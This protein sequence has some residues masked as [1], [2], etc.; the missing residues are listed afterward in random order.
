ME[1]SITQDTCLA[2]LAVLPTGIDS[3]AIGLMG[4]TDPSISKP[5]KLILVIEAIE[6]T[7]MGQMSPV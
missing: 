5:Q 3:G 2:G 6:S 4:F 1:N 7:S